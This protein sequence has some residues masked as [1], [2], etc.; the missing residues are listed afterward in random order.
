MRLQ[1]APGTAFGSAHL[2]VAALP[3]QWWGNG[4][5]RARRCG[6]LPPS[7]PNLAAVL[8]AAS[9]TVVDGDGSP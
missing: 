6:N 9:G 7:S 5:A 8:R 4:A 2:E 1:A 3:E